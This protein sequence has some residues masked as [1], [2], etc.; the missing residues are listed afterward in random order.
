MTTGFLDEKLPELA[1]AAL[2][3]QHDVRVAP[4]ELY[5]G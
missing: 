4:V 5:P 3:H 1:A 2:S